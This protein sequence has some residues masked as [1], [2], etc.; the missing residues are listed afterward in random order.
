M[1]RADERKHT[2]YFYWDARGPEIAI[3]PRSVWPEGPVD[4]GEAAE[5]IDGDVP[6]DGWRELAAEFLN[7]LKK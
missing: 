4:F 2:H 1:T 7:R 5:C 6:A 3:H